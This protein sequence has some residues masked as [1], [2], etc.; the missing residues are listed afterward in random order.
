MSEKATKSGIA[1]DLAHIDGS[2]AESQ[3]DGCEVRLYETCIVFIPIRGEPYRVHYSNIAQVESGDYSIRISTDLGERFTISRMGREYDNTAGSLSDTMNALG[4]R[5]QSLLKDVIPSADP[6]VI[7]ALARLMKD[8]KAAKR[9]DI[10]SV[11]REM[12]SA[13]EKKLEQ[14]SIWEPYQY[15][16]SIGRQ[17][18]IAA[19][20]KRGL[21]GDLTGIHVWILIPIYSSAPTGNAIAL[22]S[23]RLSSSS[24]DGELANSEAPP[25]QDSEIS[26]G[27]SATYFFR[28][29]GRGDYPAMAGNVKDLDIK[30]DNLIPKMNQLMLDINFRREPIYLSDDRLRSDPKYARYRF[31]AQ[32]VTSLKELRMLFIG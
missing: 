31:A 30:V 3:F 6:S 13:L 16:K 29:V 27:R 10:E 14:T 2:G 21:M 7:R 11:S 15:L 24:Q 20:I 4:L 22:E 23:V 17:E 9:S 28:I 12:W 25:Q 18:K 1:A 8:G 19:G 32:K 26:A 5:V